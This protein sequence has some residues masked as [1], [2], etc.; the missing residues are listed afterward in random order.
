[1]KSKNKFGPCSDCG[2]DDVLLRTS[3]LLAGQLTLH[4]DT[5][6]VACPGK[7]RGVSDETRRKLDAI[8]VSILDEAERI[9]KLIDTLALEGVTGP[10]LAAVL[11]VKDKLTAAAELLGSV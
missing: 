7:R 9:S 8:E 4:N 3:G 5:W 2:R 6:G 1:M 11:D 10:K